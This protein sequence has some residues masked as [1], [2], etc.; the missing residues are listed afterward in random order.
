MNRHPVHESAPVPTPREIEQRAAEIRAE[1]SESRHRS[2]ASVEIYQKWYPPG[3][4]YRVQTPAASIQ[5]S[6]AGIQ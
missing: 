2:R 3:V 5:R 4:V 1:W 6:G